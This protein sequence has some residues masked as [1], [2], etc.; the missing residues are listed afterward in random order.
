MRVRTTLRTALMGL[1]KI[2]PEVL[3]RTKNQVVGQ[4]VMTETGA[5]A[6]GTTTVPLDDTVPQNTEGDQYLSQAITPKDSSS[7]L[8]IEVVLV[9]AASTA[10][11]IIAA[12]FQDSTAGALAAA[13]EYAGTSG[14]LHTISF[15]YKM[16][17]GTTSSTTFKVRAGLSTT[18]T[19]TFNGAGGSR[20]FGGV[21]ASSIK[22]TEYLP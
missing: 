13:A 20:L 2:T 19:L 11:T 22:I 5:V 15:R 1:T 17:A 12:L 6:S 10:A 8:V 4:I 9:V 14:T 21:I 3:D 16:N 18:G 7:T